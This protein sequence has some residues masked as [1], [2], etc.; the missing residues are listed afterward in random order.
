MENVLITFYSGIHDKSIEIEKHCHSCYEIVYYIHGRGHSVIGEEGF[1]FESNTFSV[2]PPDV[3]HNEQYDKVTE[4]RFILCDPKHYALALNSGVYPDSPDRTLLRLFEQLESEFKT[5]K[6]NYQLK[7][8]VLTVE[9]LIEI[10]RLQRTET[11]AQLDY[12]YIKK[13][14]DE[15]YYMHIEISRLAQM[16]GY[17]YDRFRHLFKEKYKL[18]VSKYI[19]NVRLENAKR[20][21]TDSN[22]S[23]SE[24]A[25]R[26]GFASDSQ[27]IGMF[28]EAFGLTPLK[29][30]K[31]NGGQ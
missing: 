3:I 26:C 10:G 17:S 15:N 9:L 29:Y 30:R 18:S 13:F 12:E 27:F 19:L 4:L 11:K 5:R 8:D 2:Q 6:E 23:V 1:P 24:I 22:V 14:I 25:G 28:K 31:Q 21:L 7:M 16:S 20:I